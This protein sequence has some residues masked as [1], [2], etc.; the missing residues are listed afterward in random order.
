LSS[1]YVAKSNFTKQLSIYIT[2]KVHLPSYPTLFL[3]CG[4]LNKK[5]MK[6]KDIPLGE[7]ALDTVYILLLSE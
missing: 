7:R 5:F 1:V 2:A 3:P 4:A 6:I